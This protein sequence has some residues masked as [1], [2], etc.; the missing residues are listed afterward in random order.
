LSRLA[1][2][3]ITADLAIDLFEALKVARRLQL[4]PALSAAVQA[5]GVPVIDAELQRLVPVAALNHL[6]ALGLR[7]E[8]VF[9]V[10]PLIAHAPPLIGYY[11]MLLGISRKEF[12]QSKRLAYGPWLNAEESG[13]LPPRL[14]AELDPFCRALITPLVELVQA[15]HVFDDRDLS[16]LALLT[17]G[18]TLQ[19]ARNTLIGARAAQHVFTAMRA[20]IAPW[21]TFEHARLI[22]FTTPGGRTFEAVAGSDPDLRIDEGEGTAV[23]P[24]VAMEIKGGGDASNAHNRAGE[25]EKSQLKAVRMG[26][27]QRWTVIR[28]SGVNRQRIAEETPSSTAIFEAGDV[29][30]QAG[31]DWDALREQLG[32]LVGEPLIGVVV[33]D[34]E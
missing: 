2:K 16:D 7:G 30:A 14:R 27:A 9:P 6:A 12:S 23:T 13:R 21:I 10:P 18:P 32:A 29:I 33:D 5:I 26:Y 22:R 17:L 28:M 1:F 34:G 3:P 4:H 31:P 20:L 25:A 19:G 11:R 15:M 24:L 8:R